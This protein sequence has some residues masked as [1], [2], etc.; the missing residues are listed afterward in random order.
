MEPGH[1]FKTLPARTVLTA[2]RDRS[3][4]VLLESSLPA[5]EA[6]SSLLFLDPVE[7]VT[8]EDPAELT[9]CIGRLEEA[10]RDGLWAAG[11]FAYEAGYA[12]EESL[13]GTDK[14][15]GPLL[16]WGIY[17]QPY[18]FDHT[19][20]SFA[21]PPDLAGGVEGT[22]TCSTA[23]GDFTFSRSDYAA[24]VR[25]IQDHIA[26]GDT[27]QVN[28]TMKY[29]FPF[30]GDSAGLY[31]SFRDNQPVPYGAFIRHDDRTVLSASPELF[32]RRK[33]IAVKARPMKGTLRRGRTP[34]EDRRLAETLRSDPKN[35]AENVMIVDLLRNDLGRICVPGSIE[36][37]DLFRVERYDTLLQMTSAVT[38][39]LADDVSLGDMLKA[40]FPCGSVTGAPKI[41]TMQII[42]DLEG[43]PRGVYCGAI[44]YLGPGRESVL[45][46]PIRT[47]VIRGK[48]GE[49]GIG[50]G[51][52]ADS[53]PFEEYSECL[54]KARF[55]THRR[56]PL[57]LIETIRW[58]PGSGFR[59]LD[60]H[61]ERMDSSAGFFGMPF[62]PEDARQLLQAKAP[63]GGDPVLLRLRLK[64]AGE[65]DVSPRPLEAPAKLPAAV[66][67]SACIM[68]SGDIFL[69]HKTTRREVYD[70]ELRRARA[71]GLFE[72][73]FTNEAGELT[74]GAFTNIFVE[75]DGVLLTPPLRAGV[76]PGI[77]RRRL[78]EGRDPRVIEERLFPRDLAGSG[79]V[80]IGND[81]RG[82]MEAKIVGP[83]EGRFPLADKG[84][85]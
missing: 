12:L 26:A 68:D 70:R 74:E 27:Y 41:S 24:A 21:P 75:R 19:G 73:L 28:F 11:Y 3:P 78:L 16:W 83:G 20:G 37:S 84:I 52:V 77:L 15:G 33:N 34:A 2:L 59:S 23:P 7:I 40:A 54:L 9:S 4:L 80:F 39:T 42:A 65:M 60:E 43:E 1:R 61:L 46:V 44:G 47:A 72:I 55:L 8:T 49:M 32:L 36:V 29:R 13:Q 71:E 51:I 58:D 35:R 25:R 45:S 82:L 22:L 79:R 81:A 64:R 67:L 14:P 31:L 6:Q 57:D 5:P 30:S 85:E 17:R 50:S 48:E 53:E 69:R 10:W 18:V 63:A 38:G 56:S 62:S 66:G 76:L